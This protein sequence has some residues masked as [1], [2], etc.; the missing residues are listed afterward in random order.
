MKEATLFDFCACFFILE[1]VTLKELEE[2]PANPVFRIKPS[3]YA[4]NAIISHRVLILNYRQ[5]KK[6]ISLPG[7]WHKIELL[8]GGLS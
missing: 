5:W 6:K 4:A 7:L 3:N 1:E 8:N 2:R